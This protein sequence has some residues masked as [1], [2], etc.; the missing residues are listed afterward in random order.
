MSFRSTVHSDDHIQT[1]TSRERETATG[2]ALEEG[3]EAIGRRDQ[4]VSK[5]GKLAQRGGALSKETE[6]NPSNPTLH[7]KWHT[8]ALD[9]DARVGPAIDVISRS[10]KSASL[11]ARIGVLLVSIERSCAKGEEFLLST[12]TADSQEQFGGFGAFTAEMP[13]HFD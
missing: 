11:D 5:L 13:G 2:T 10:R 9:A 1:T 8:Y 3:Q 7:S 6:D 12:R 4:E